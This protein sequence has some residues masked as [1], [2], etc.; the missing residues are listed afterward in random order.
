M[1]H[2]MTDNAKG[3]VINQSANPAAFELA[4]QDYDVWLLNCRGN[5]YSRIHKTYKYTQPEF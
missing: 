4:D 3:F 5:L 1:V 2:G